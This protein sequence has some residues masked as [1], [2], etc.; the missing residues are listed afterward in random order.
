MPGIDFDQLRADISMEDVLRVIG[1]RPAHCTG[2]QWYGECPLHESSTRGSSGRRRSFSVNVALG[3]YYCH[4]CLSRGH[5]LQLWAAFTKQK[6]HPAAI[7]L[8]QVLG[9]EIPWIHRW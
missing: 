5:Q 6:L 8:C 2:D 9:R 3:C 1:F 7:D 4:R